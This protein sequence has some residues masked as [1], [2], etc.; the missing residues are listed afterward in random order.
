M[1]GFFHTFKHFRS[2]AYIY[3]ALGTCNLKHAGSKAFVFLYSTN[4]PTLSCSVFPESPPA[5]L[6]PTLA[7]AKLL[8]SYLGCQIHLLTLSFNIFPIQGQIQ[9]F[10]KATKGRGLVEQKLSNS[11]PFPLIDFT[12]KARKYDSRIDQF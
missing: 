3:F 2:G 4:S 9:S 12:I 8:L 11:T 10:F 6:L 1:K 5:A 7:D